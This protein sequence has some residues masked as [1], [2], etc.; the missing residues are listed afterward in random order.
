MAG[1]KVGCMCRT[2]QVYVYVLALTYVTLQ[3][4]VTLQAHHNAQTHSDEFVMSALV[5]FDKVSVLIHELLVFEVSP[6][7]HVCV[8]CKTQV[9]WHCFSCTSTNATSSC[10]E[11]LVQNR[12]LRMH[13]RLTCRHACRH[14]YHDILPSTYHSP[15]H[16]LF[17]D[18]L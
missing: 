7:A 6:H 12:S 8:L 18:P 2:Q 11:V 4:L 1:C 5:S 15:V 14:A 16:H 3:R 10:L 17:S 13:L 9:C